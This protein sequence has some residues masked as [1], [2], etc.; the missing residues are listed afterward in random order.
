MGFVVLWGW[1]VVVVLWWLGVVVVGGVFCGFSVVCFCVV[2]L[3]ALVE[4]F[5][6]VQWN[7]GLALWNAFG[8]HHGPF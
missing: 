8:N 5:V 6:A 2:G 4:V 1:G 7:V 3:L